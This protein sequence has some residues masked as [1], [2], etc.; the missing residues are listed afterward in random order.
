MSMKKYIRYHETRNKNFKV[1]NHFGWHG[2][3]F[4]NYEALLDLKNN[5][6]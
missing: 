2:K 1:E 6:N 3:R 4:K 5:V